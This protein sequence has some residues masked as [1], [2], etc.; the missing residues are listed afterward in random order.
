MIN[1]HFKKSFLT[2]RFALLIG[3]GSSE[4]RK[5]RPKVVT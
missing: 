2:A 5:S 1:D 3:R 4:P